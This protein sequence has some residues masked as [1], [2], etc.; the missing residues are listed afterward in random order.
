VGGMKR[1]LAQWSI[2]EDE[3]T[4]PQVIAAGLLFLLLLIV[5]PFLTLLVAAAMDVL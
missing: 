2:S 3:P 4:W 1:W 5:F